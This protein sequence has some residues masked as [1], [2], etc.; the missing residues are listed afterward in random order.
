M[1]SEERAKLCLLPTIHHHHLTNFHTLLEYFQIA[2]SG[3]S[4]ARS[5][6]VFT[7]VKDVLVCISFCSALVFYVL[8]SIHFYALVLCSMFYVLCSMFRVYCGGIV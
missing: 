4:V 7:V 5:G 2:D 1:S 6:I 3:T 8:Y